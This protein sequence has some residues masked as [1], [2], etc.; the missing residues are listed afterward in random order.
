MAYRKTPRMTSSEYKTLLEL[1]IKEE[2][3]KTS[4]RPKSSLSSPAT[5]LL[6]RQQNF[7]IEIFRSIFDDLLGSRYCRK[8]MERN[9]EREGAGYIDRCLQAQTK[10]LGFSLPP[11][12]FMFI[13][14]G[15]GLACIY[16]F[17]VGWTDVSMGRQTIHLVYLR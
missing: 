13:G 1:I 17:V 2:T 4:K 12:L 14:G 10:P 5:T 7:E 8:A 3:Q 15:F 6:P 16:G 11:P 9:I